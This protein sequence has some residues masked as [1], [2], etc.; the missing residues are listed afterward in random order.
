MR[1]DTKTLNCE[2]VAVLPTNAYIPTG[3]RGNTLVLDINKNEAI[4]TNVVFQ[5]SHYSIF[6]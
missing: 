1:W 6:C 4:V 2:T 5:F 3:A